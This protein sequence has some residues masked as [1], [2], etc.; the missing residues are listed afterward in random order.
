MFKGEDP[1]A[2]F[3]KFFKDATEETVQDEGGNAGGGHHFE[4][5]GMNVNFGGFGGMP[6]MPG[7]DGDDAGQGGYGGMGG[8]ASQGGYGGGGGGSSSSFSMSFSSNS[9]DNGG[10]G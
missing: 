2:N 7:M 5:P 8:D 9:M 10:G 6:G 1:F 3:N 4:M